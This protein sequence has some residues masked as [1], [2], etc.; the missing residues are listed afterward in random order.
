MTISIHWFGWR[1]NNNN[2][3]QHQTTATTRL[4]IKVAAQ[5]GQLVAR[6]G[7]KAFRHPQQSDERRQGVH[8]DEEPQWLQHLDNGGED[9]ALRNSRHQPGANN[10][11][12]NRIAAVDSRS[13]HAGA[14]AGVVSA[15]ARTRTVGRCRYKQRT[16]G[17]RA[18][19]AG[20][21]QDKQQRNQ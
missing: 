20:E 6:L 5:R 11:S 12:G 4:E 16:P 9:G 3:N 13:S 10:S 17:R 15:K 14:A 8:Q 7:R 19:A 18:A 2:K 21:G 1:N